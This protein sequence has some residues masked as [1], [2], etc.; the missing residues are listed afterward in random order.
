MW[1]EW[2][3]NSGMSAWRDCASVM[4]LPHFEVLCYLVL[5]LLPPWS[6]INS[7]TLF[8]WFFICYSVHMMLSVQDLMLKQETIP[9]TLS[10]EF[11][12]PYVRFVMKEIKKSSVFYWDSVLS[13]ELTKQIGHCEAIVKLAFW[14]FV[15]FVIVSWIH[16][17]KGKVRNWK[18][19]CTI[20]SCWPIYVIKLVDK[21]N[22]Y[23]FK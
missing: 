16:S 8:L 4:L 13:T 11:S 5:S 20:S 19:S 1:W 21:L 10:R 14:A 22:Q 15:P 6:K 18:V 9:V 2:N 3:Q 7:S 23:I 17:D 12:W